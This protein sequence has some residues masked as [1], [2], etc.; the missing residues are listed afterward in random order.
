MK[1]ETIEGLK[2]RINCLERLVKETTDRVLLAEACMSAVWA[3]PNAGNQ[4]AVMKSQ[5]TPYRTEYPIA[6]MFEIK[7]SS[8]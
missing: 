8:A 1:D 2:E 5:L 4:I 6:K 7:E 3:Y